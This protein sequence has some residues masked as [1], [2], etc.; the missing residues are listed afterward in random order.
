MNRLL[1]NLVL[2]DLRPDGIWQMT[3]VMK[4]VLRYHISRLPNRK[5]SEDETRYPQSPA[6]MR[7]F[8]VKFFVRHYLQ[9]QN[10]LL[11]YM[12]SQ[13][14]AEPSAYRDRKKSQH[15]KSIPRE[16]QTRLILIRIIA[17]YIRLL[18]KERFLISPLRNFHQFTQLHFPALQRSLKMLQI[19]G[20]S[21]HR[22]IETSLSKLRMVSIRW[23]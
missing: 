14:F 10:C 7:A 5:V 8:L 3:D 11:D 12:I 4:S 16:I 20:V 6:S 21:L 9:I 2:K 18:R 22:L 23:L 17:A 13:D 15:K 1:K 19:S